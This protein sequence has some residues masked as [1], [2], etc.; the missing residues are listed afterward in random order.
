V[1]QAIPAR[2][3]AAIHGQILTALRSSGSQDEAQ[4]AFH[5]EE[6]DDVA[7]VLR[8]APAAARRAAAL[9]SHREAAAQFER[10]LRSRPS[11]QGSRPSRSRACTTSWPPS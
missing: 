9:A 6:A 2:R 5:A 10:A 1:E 3:R 11:H 4:M 7:A 8:Y